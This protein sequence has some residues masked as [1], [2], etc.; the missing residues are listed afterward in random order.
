MRQEHP[1]PEV[2]RLINICRFYG[3]PYERLVDVTEWIVGKLKLT[4]SK[5]KNFNPWFEK[6]DEIDKMLVA[7]FSSPDSDRTI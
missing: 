1:S 5:P 3:C 6:T 2:Q 4:S 7:T